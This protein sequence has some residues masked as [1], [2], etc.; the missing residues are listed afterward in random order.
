MSFQS[1]YISF[2]AG[3]SI[4]FLGLAGCA[5]KASL[6]AATLTPI[7]TST[8]ASSP[9]PTEAATATT[10]PSTDTPEPVETITA[11]PTSLP[12]TSAA[13]TSTPGSSWNGIPVLPDATEPI[14]DGNTY[15]Y[16]TASTVAEV[17]D[18]YTK[19]MADLGWELFSTDK[20][21]TISITMVFQKGTQNV[22]IALAPHPV[23]AGHTLV[24]IV[25]Q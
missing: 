3:L 14:E 6:P 15:S 7:Q 23:E 21:D 8:A 10:L 9:I 17:T 13:A 20:G 24:V 1:K 4:C 22:T 25:I 5:S 18:Y 2:I 12:G 16:T 11:Q 19:E